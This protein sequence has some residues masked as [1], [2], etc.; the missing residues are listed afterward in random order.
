M[1]QVV[2]PVCRKPTS[3]P[4][5]QAGK[6]EICS[7][8]SNQIPIPSSCPTKAEADSKKPPW[9]IRNVF[10]LVKIA[11]CPRMEEC[12]EDVNMSQVFGRIII[13]FCGE[14]AS[15]IRYVYGEMLK[16]LQREVDTVYIAVSGPSLGAAWPAGIYESDAIA[17][18]R[19]HVIAMYMQ[20][21]ASMAAA[22]ARTHPGED[23][24]DIIVFSIVLIFF[25]MLHLRVEDDEDIIAEQSRELSEMLGSELGAWIVNTDDDS[26]R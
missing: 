6:V 19:Q 14:Y 4:D 11:F 10:G 24:G 9:E 20:T 7:H 2:C 3:T 13:D 25:Q 22:F 16:K 26:R 8:C 21:M 15:E 5:S 23:K 12:Q 1:I 18:G 17:N